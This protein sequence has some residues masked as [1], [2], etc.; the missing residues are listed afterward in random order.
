M[1]KNQYLMEHEGEIARLETKTDTDTVRRQAL[2]AGLDKGMRVA[3][4][5]C[6]TGKTTEVLQDIV[7]PSGEVVGIDSSQER[8]TYAKQTYPCSTYLV[9]D[10]RSVPPDIGQFDFIW[11]RFFL[12]YYKTDAFEIV[13]SLGSLLKSEGI[14]C[15][16]DLDYNCMTHHGLDEDL[17]LSLIGCMQYLEEQTNF[18][19]YAGRKLYS[20]LFDLGYANIE[21]HMEP[22]HLLHGTLNPTDEKNWNA[23]IDI[24]LGQS[25]YRFPEL[26]GGFEEFRRRIRQYLKQP[27]R[28][29]YTPAIL[30]RGVKPGRN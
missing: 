12:E 24:A 27:R 22:H 17:E 1:E 20:Y 26:E 16:I 11:V 2:W 7:G 23:K 4:I 13:D 21:V 14:M 28:F 3:D 5:G 6:G 19:P 30:C 25:G 10:I 8:I 9:N 29:T 18:D 15:L